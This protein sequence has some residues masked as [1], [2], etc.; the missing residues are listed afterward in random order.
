MGYERS[1]KLDAQARRGRE[2]GIPGPVVASTVALGLRNMEWLVLSSSE[3]KR[4]S[5]RSMQRG[6]SSSYHV[7]LCHLELD[8]R[9]GGD[10][11]DD[12]ERVRRPSCWVSDHV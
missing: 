10:R 11:R 4:W 3:G 5:D 12:E 8:K 1:R 6:C 7:G 9:E 2:L